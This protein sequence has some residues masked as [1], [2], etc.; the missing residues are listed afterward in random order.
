MSGGKTGGGGLVKQGSGTAATDQNQEEELTSGA[1]GTLSQ[2][3]GPV[4]S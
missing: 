1:Q 3:E 2:F 4:T